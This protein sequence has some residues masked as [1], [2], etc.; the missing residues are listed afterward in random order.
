MDEIYTYVVPLPVGVDEVVLPCA[1]GHT[2]YLADR[3]DHQTQLKKYRHAV[4][5]IRSNDFKKQDVQEI[6]CEVHG[7]E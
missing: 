5:H 4:R 3:L 2:I 6:E 1:D 7:K